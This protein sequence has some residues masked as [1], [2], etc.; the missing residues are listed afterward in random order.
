MMRTTTATLL[1]VLM[2]GSRCGALFSF[3]ALF[4]VRFEWR[5][6]VP[7]F[8]SCCAWLAFVLLFSL[9]PV[10]LVLVGALGLCA[11]RCLVGLA[12]P[13][14]CAL[15]S[16]CLPLSGEGGFGCVPAFRGLEHPSRTESVRLRAVPRRRVLAGSVVAARCGGKLWC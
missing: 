10:P 12:C 5:L 3:P 11:L 14:P 15:N 1:R 16:V 6:F 9:R 8:V 2:Q 4:G 13:L 7:A